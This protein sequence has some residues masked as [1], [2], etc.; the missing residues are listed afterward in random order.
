MHPD[1]ILFYPL[2]GSSIFMRASNEYKKH[3][4]GNLSNHLKYPVDI[5]KFQGSVPNF[6]TE[7]EFNLKYREN[8]DPEH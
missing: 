1:N 7:G 2:W 6:L 8:P 3:Q 5:I 4:F